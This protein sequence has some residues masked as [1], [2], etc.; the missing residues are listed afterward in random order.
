MSSEPAQLPLFPA[1][2]IPTD[3]ITVELSVG[4][5][6]RWRRESDGTI[7]LE[8]A[9]RKLAVAKERFGRRG[10]DCFR[11]TGLLN[12]KGN[13]V[14][15]RNL[16][17]LAR[18]VNRLLKW[19]KRLEEHAAKANERLARLEETAGIPIVSS[20]AEQTPAFARRALRLPELHRLPPPRPM[21]PENLNLDI[22]DAR[23]ARPS[24]EGA[25]FWTPERSVEV[26]NQSKLTVRRKGNAKLAL[27]AHSAIAN[28]VRSSCYEC[29]KGHIQ[30]EASLGRCTLILAEKDLETLGVLR[31]VRRKVEGRK[32]NAVNCFLLRTT[33][34][35]VVPKSD[36]P[37]SKKETTGNLENGQ[38]DKKTEEEA[39]S[40]LPDVRPNPGAKPCGAVENRALPTG[41]ESTD[42]FAQPIDVLMSTPLGKRLAKFL[43][44]S[45]MLKEARASG[46]EWSRI[47]RKEADSLE[48]LLDQAERICA[49]LPSGL[50]RAKFLTKRLGD[51]RG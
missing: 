11:A 43:G 5:T 34:R 2:P 35:E 18:N 23:A 6:A 38:T 9:G 25:F 33:R 28:Y 24:A 16:A 1:D 3:W 31:V 15:S 46:A 37:P 12:E 26:I 50:A 41:K 44:P 7:S 32:E 27:L 19:Q 40:P 48:N 49:E 47:L 30:H 10:V 39:E 14:Q 51:R 29:H 17:F 36:D 20:I 8:V 22:K 21:S 45:Q 42:R 13:A 4:E